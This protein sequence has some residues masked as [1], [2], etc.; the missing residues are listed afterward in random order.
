MLTIFEY[1][2]SYNTDCK[3]CYFSHKG[4]ETYTQW[5]S[6]AKEAMKHSSLEHTFS[7][8]DEIRLPFKLNLQKVFMRIKLDIERTNDTEGETRCIYSELSVLY[9]LSQMWQTL[10]SQMWWHIA[11]GMWLSSAHM[12]TGKVININSRS[13]LTSILI[14]STSI[15]ILLA[16]NVCIGAF[17]DPRRCR[18]TNWKEDESILI[19][20]EQEINFYYI[21]PLRFLD[22]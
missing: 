5:F 16:S 3:C 11:R 6:E 17:W 9:S 2:I 15:I 4:E 7:Q 10:I 8:R 20:Q 19:G 22:Y 14:S 12:N 13:A 21:K 1:L 18:G